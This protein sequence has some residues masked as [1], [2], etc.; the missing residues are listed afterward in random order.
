M[1]INLPPIQQEKSYTCLPAC[2]R[3]VLHGD[4]GTHA[5][6]VCGFDGDE[7]LYL[8]TALGQKVRLDIMIFLRA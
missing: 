6:T 5:V 3:I 1:R 8:D 4:F 7:I 2:L